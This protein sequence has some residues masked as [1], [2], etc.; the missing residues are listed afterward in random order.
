MPLTEQMWRVLHED[1]PVR[2][3]VLELMRRDL[4]HEST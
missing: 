4:K 3:V 1:K 2:E